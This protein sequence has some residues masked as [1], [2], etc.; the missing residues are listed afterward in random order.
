MEWTVTLSFC[1]FNFVPACLHVR[2]I[3][4]REDGSGFPVTQTELAD[5]GLEG[6]SAH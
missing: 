2:E 5:L 1:C 4:L 3:R 6:E